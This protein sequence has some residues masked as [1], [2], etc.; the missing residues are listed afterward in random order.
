MATA[1]ALTRV[2]RFGATDLP[3][4]DSDLNQEQVLE[5]FK[6]MFPALRYGK[7]NEVGVE[8]DQLVYELVPNEYAANG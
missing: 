3:D 1:T 4:P 5:H 2:F 7:V 8:N 6:G